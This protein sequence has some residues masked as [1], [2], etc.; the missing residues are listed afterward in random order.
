MWPAVRAARSVRAPLVAGIS[1]PILKTKL[2]VPS[3][4]CGLKRPGDDH[5]RGHG[6]PDFGRGGAGIG[7]VEIVQEEAARRRGCDELGDEFRGVRGSGG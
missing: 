3:S 7:E 6:A 5:L 2:W 4:A 1:S